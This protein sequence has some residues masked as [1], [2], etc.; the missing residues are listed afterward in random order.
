MAALPTCSRPAGLSA[1]GQP[2]ADTGPLCSHHASH[3]C[4]RGALPRSPLPLKGTL[5]TDEAGTMLAAQ[6]P[7]S[8]LGAGAKAKQEQLWRPGRRDGLGQQM[9]RALTPT[10]GPHQL[11]GGH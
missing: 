10:R 11:E 8:L 1:L 2:R 5:G 4:S 9:G 6:Q 7:G 3:P